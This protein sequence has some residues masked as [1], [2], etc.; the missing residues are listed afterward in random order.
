MV[1]MEAAGVEPAG[2]LCRR[3]DGLVGF[4]QAPD[5]PDRTVPLIFRPPG[6]S[7]TRTRGLTLPTNERA[8]SDKRH[9]Y[10]G[11]TRQPPH[12]NPPKIPLSRHFVPHGEIKHLLAYLILGQGHLPRG[13]CPVPCSVLQACRGGSTVLL[14][15]C[16]CG[17]AGPAQARSKAGPPSIRHPN[18]SVYVH[19]AS[20]LDPLT[21]SHNFTPHR[22][23]TQP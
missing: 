7:Q 23:L 5:F 1:P 21:F 14:C 6:P 17:S 18:T 16:A 19:D 13:P 15:C 9:P 8:Y 11:A 4:R 12:L 20:P 3:T 22:H 10:P 2:A